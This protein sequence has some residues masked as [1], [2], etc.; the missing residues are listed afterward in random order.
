[1][2]L[3]ARILPYHAKIVAKPYTDM[4]AELFYVAFSLFVIG[5]FRV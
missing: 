2:L 4:Q 3:P 1:M 5:F